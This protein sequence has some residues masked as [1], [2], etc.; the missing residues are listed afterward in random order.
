M[1][2]NERRTLLLTVLKEANAPIKG[3][4]LADRF[5]VSRQIIV[6]DIALLRAANHP[7]LSTTNGYLFLH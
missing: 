4:D 6:Q 3:N 1:T 5:H 7:I 2:G